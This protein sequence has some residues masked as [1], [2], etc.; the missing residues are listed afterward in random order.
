MKFSEELV[1]AAIRFAELYQ[2]E[3]GDKNSLDAVLLG[4]DEDFQKIV[5]FYLV[6]GSATSD[7]VLVYDHEQNIQPQKSR[8]FEVVMVLRSYCDALINDLRKLHD[9]AKVN[10]H[11]VLEGDVFAFTGI[12][13]INQKLQGTGFFV[14]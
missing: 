3:S 4:L 13:E 12:D 10:G 6:K 2:K 11:A 1:I 8:Q 7:L 5:T 9:R 14:K